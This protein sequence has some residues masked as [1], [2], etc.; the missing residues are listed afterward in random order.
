MSRLQKLAARE[1]LE[2][3]IIPIRIGPETARQQRQREKRER[4]GIRIPVP[5]GNPP[6]RAEERDAMLERAREVQDEVERGI[7]PPAPVDLSEEILDEVEP[8]VFDLLKAAARSVIEAP[9]ARVLPRR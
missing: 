3:G 7:R 9:R 2:K 4:Q 8:P 6:L 5:K 1:R